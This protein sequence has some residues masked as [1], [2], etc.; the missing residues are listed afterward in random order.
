LR[1]ER[2]PESPELVAALD[3]MVSKAVS[4]KDEIGPL[5]VPLFRGNVAGKEVEITLFN[6]DE[7]KPVL[8]MAAMNEVL[9]HESNIYGLPPDPAALGD[10]Y[11]D[12]YKDGI[13]AGLRFIDLIVAGFAAEVESRIRDGKTEPIEERWKIAKRAQQV[14]LHIPEAAY[15][16]ISACIKSSA[17]AA[18]CSSD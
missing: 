5:E 11:A 8:S 15:D 4:A 17:S 13:R 9:V 7:G 12:I 2:K 6:W 3:D 18:R 10:K 16:F 1:A 14:N